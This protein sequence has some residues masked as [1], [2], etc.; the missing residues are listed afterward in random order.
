MLPATHRLHK[1]TEI[2]S[3]I[4]TGQTFFLSEFIFKFAKNKEESTKI[5]FVVST[6]VDKNAVG[7]NRLKRQMR[8]AIGSFLPDIKPG[9]SILI[10]AKKQALDL[11][12][13]A[14][15]KQFKFAATKIKIYAGK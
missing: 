4:Q 1:Q 12:F 9:Y 6:K 13:A 10:I 2:K 14:I 15:V 11:D 3:L 5:G 7:R 8:E